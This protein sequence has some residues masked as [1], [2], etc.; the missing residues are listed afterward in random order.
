MITFGAGIGT[1]F[2]IG[3]GAALRN[4]GPFGIVFAYFIESLIVY[5]MFIQVGEMTTY[6]PI[7]GGFINQIRLYVDDATAFAQGISFAFNWMVCLAAELTAGISVLKMWDTEGVVTTAEYIIIF[8]VIYVLCNLWPVKAYGY[9]EYVQS[10]VKIISMAG[11]TLFMF[12]STCGGLPK[13]NGA[14]GYKYWKNPGWIR[15]GIKGI[16]LALSQ[17]GFA[18]GGG[19]HIAVV[20]GEVKHPRRFIPRCTQPIFWRFCI[21]F[22]GNSWLITMN[23]P[24]DDDMLNNNHGSLASPYIITMKRGGV[25]FLPHLLNALILL[26]VISCGNS[27]VYIASRSLVACSDIKL[28]HPIFGWKDRAGRPW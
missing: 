1:G 11:V 10:F 13:S 25:K 2:W 15:N 27:S 14:I 8:F 6:Q 19:E 9:I 4:G 22:I 28:I 7:H 5:I 17:A 16:I 26:A 18:F 24:Y 21:F 23:V 20:A 12:V 3:M